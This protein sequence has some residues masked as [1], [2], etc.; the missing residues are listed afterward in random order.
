MTPYEVSD[1]AEED[2]ENSVMLEAPEL[3]DSYW[4]FE[5]AAAYWTRTMISVT[6][7]R[8][9]YFESPIYMRLRKRPA[10]AVPRSM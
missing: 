4:V 10:A 5:K 6:P 3:M 7:C 8:Y 1:P 2:E 9:T